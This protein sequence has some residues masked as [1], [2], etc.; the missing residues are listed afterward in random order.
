[1][2][3]ASFRSRFLSQ[4]NNSF[5]SGGMSLAFNEAQFSSF[6]QFLKQE[7]MGKLAIRKAVAVVGKQSDGVWVLA[8]DI[9]I[10][11]N[12]DV[13][14][15]SL[16]THMWMDMI[17]RDGLG[18]VTAEEVLPCLPS[19]FDPDTSVLCTIVKNMRVIMQ[20]NFFPAILMA[21]GA[22]MALHYSSVIQAGGCPIVIAN[23]G[24]ETGK[25]TAIRLALSLFGK[26]NMSP[27]LY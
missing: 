15:T 14:P 2:E 17:I 8:P 12:G 9:H 4:L 13:I 23:G 7:S 18:S 16:Q 20:H 3:S 25:S 10:N 11:A 22:I 6:I 24:C 5:G 26:I 1:M 27:V 19:Q 21:G